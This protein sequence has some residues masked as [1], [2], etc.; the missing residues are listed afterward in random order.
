MNIL[1]SILNLFNKS[2]NANKENIQEM[3]Q[4]NDIH[5]TVLNNEKIN[6]VITTNENKKIIYK[7][8]D[9]LEFTIPES[10]VYL[11]FANK[12]LEEVKRLSSSKLKIYSFE[13]NDISFRIYKSYE[14]YY[15]LEVMMADDYGMYYKPIGYYN[16]NN[17]GNITDIY[18]INEFVNDYNDVSYMLDNT[19]LFR[20]L[21]L[22]DNVFIALASRQVLNVTR[23]LFNSDN[24][25]E[26][27][28][29]DISRAQYKPIIVNNLKIIVKTSMMGAL[30]ALYDDDDNV[31]DEELLVIFK[32][33]F[34]GMSIHCIDREYENL[35]DRELLSVFK[36]I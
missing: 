27:N 5:K 32:N 22:I 20:E 9:T 24:Y 21:E 28:H 11:L 6:D 25:S 4:Y 15:N 1:K 18:I 23:E 10:F 26:Y 7:Y 13:Y 34:E 8:D 31:F 30:E 29:L 14:G 12:T 19:K 3:T 2:T 35:K 33:S 36:N 16:Q 17:T